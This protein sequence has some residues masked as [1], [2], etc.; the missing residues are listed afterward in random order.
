MATRS[1][2]CSW[3]KTFRT[4]GPS[5]VTRSNWRRA[6][7]P[8][9]FTSRTTEA[10]CCHGGRDKFLNPFLVRQGIIR[11]CC[12]V[13]TNVIVQYVALKREQTCCI[14][15]CHHGY[16][17]RCTSRVVRSLQSPGSSALCRYL[18]LPSKMRTMLSHEERPAELIT[19][20][21]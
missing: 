15:H 13:K 1:L 2:H 14:V 12:N 21:W 18:L 11:H 5:S 19:L 9:R 6:S 20:H 10:S 8:K 17:F 16:S 3:C 4:T 7:G